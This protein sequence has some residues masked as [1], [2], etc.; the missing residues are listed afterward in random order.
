MQIF[1]ASMKR[2]T[3]NRIKMAFGGVNDSIHGIND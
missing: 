2:A 3:V 1:I